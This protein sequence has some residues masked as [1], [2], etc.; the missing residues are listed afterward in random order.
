MVYSDI[1]ARY[2]FDKSP[3]GGGQLEVFAGIKNMF[4]EEGPLLAAGL[5]DGDTGVNTNAAVYDAIGRSF[6]VGG[7]VKF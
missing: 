7:K 3:F 1:Q 5:T 4:D 6:Y 2:T